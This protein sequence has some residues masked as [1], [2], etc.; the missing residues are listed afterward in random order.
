M[1]NPYLTILDWE[2]VRFV[3]HETLRFVAGSF[4]ETKLRD[5]MRGADLLDYKPKLADSVFRL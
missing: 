5:D 2:N 1:Q 4:L 3:L